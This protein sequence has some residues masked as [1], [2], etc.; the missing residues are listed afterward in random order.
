MAVLSEEQEMLRDAAKAWAD[1]RSPI[2]ALRRVRDG[3]ADAAFDLALWKEIGELGWAGIVTPEAYGGADL[4]NLTMGLVLAE[5]GRTL[6]ASPL[7]I[8]G[9]AGATA[10]TRGGS[11]AQKEAWLPKIASGAAIISLAVDEGA[12][13]APARIALA[14][15]RESEGF[16]LNGAKMFVMEGMSAD[17][18]IVAAR[19]AGRAGEIDGLTL[20]LVESNAGGLERSRLKL[21]DSRGYAAL[22]FA[23]V[24]VGADAVIGAVDQGWAILEPTLDRA[25]A[26]LCAEMLGSAEHAFAITLDYLKTRVQFGQVIGAFQALQHRAAGLYTELELAR[27]T[28]EAALT[29]LDDDALDA[30]ELVSLAKAKMSDTFH[31]VSN[32]MVQ[33]HGGIGMTDAHICGFYMR[34]ARVCEAAFGSAAY[35]R[36]RYARLLR[37]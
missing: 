23:D 21:A 13:H 10:L 37:Y 4:G 30:A 8:S 26:G 17:A 12:H 9:L 24:K 27:S 32:E 2:N 5:L 7:L 1:E 31:L 15:R 11:P 33:L 34:R 6:A 36:D 29:A 28:V 20:F 25:C 16:V 3:G 35:H 19:T 22:A 18:F 14:A